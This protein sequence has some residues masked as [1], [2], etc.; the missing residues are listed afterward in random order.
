ME[1]TRHPTD[2]ETTPADVTELDRSVRVKYAVTRHSCDTHP[3]TCIVFASSTC[4]HMRRQHEIV[5]SAVVC[6]RY[7][8]AV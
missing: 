1:V 7:Q 3:I 4:R 2:L 6:G 5:C 8:A